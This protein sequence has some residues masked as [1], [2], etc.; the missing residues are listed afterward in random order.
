MN[1]ASLHDDNCFITLTYDQEHLP[2]NWSLRKED[3]Q[4]FMKRL[5]KRF[6]ETRIRYYQCGEYGERGGRPHYHALL[7]GWKPPDLVQLRTEGDH[8][9]YGS[10]ILT[11]VWGLGM[12]VVGEVTFESASYV[13]QYCMKKK[14][15]KGAK[16]YQVLEAD[17][18]EVFEVEPPY[19]TMSRRPGIGAEWFDRYKGDCYPSDTMI[20]RG[21]EMQPPKYYD[22]LLEK[23]DAE[24]YEMIKARRKERMEKKDR[25]SVRLWSTDK[26]NKSLERNKMLRKL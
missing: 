17:T 12:T 3:Y 11:E 14:T 20:S 13:A 16:E 4:K 22:G 23:S 26:K 9:L 7:F 2:E 5:R 24:L 21:R 10:A 19:A 8:I 15:G 18:G 25:S 6:S 1:E